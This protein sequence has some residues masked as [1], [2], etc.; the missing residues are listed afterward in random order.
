MA[1]LMCEVLIDATPSTVFEL[2]TDPDLKQCWFG[3]EVELDPR[4]GGVYR[5]LVA[6]SHPA[7]GEFVEV[8]ANESVV[9]TFGWDEPGHPIPAGSTTVAITLSPEGAK[10][11]VQLV[12]RGLPEDAVAD[13]TYGWNHYLGRLAIIAEGGDPGPD[14]EMSNPSTEG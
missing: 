7:L 8:S 5:A 4:P 6:G 14:L 9:F 3:T 10:T 2:L 13:H 12:H 11:R 1:E